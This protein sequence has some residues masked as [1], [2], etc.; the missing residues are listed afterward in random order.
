[1]VPCE[2]ED[3]GEELASISAAYH[4]AIAC[5]VTHD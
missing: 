5:K 2:D 4:V 1:M 3:D